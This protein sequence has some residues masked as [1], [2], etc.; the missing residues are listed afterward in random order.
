M[1]LCIGENSVPAS[2]SSVGVG[3]FLDAETLEETVVVLAAADVLITEVS[4]LGIA[5]MME[6]NIIICS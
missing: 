4:V 1:I 5:A 3:G 6:Y 2:D